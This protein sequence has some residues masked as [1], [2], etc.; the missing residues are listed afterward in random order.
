MQF[1][2][3]LAYA[4]SLDAQDELA[5]F[6]KEFHF[7]QIDGKNIVYLCGNSLGLQPKQTKIYLEK[8]LE[9]WANYAV[10]GHFKVAEPW[11][12]YHHLL[13]S[14]LANLLGAKP[15]EVTAMNNLTS[16]LHLMMVSFYRPSSKRYKILM[17]AGAFPSDMYAVESQVR[18][19]GLDPQKAIVEVKPREGEE[20]LRTV[21]I[22]SNIEKHADELALVLF[23][24]IQYYTGQ[25]FDISALA[26][27]TRDAGA[28]FGVDLAHAIGNVPLSLHEWEVDFAVWCTYKYLNSGPG[29]SAGLFVHEKHGRNFDL[30]RMA[31]WWGHDQGERFLMQKGFK[32]MP[33]AD[34]WQQANSNILPLAAQRASLDLFMK[35][36]KDQL[37]AKSLLLTAYLEYILKEIDGGKDIIHIITPQN[38]EERGAQLSIS[39]SRGGRPVFDKLVAAGVIGDWREPNVI[40]M[41]PAPLYNSFEDV[42][43]FG[44]V[45]RQAMA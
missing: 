35:A 21:D 33:G 37:R 42:Y 32:P 13:K 1:E 6:R 27:A 34:G 4:Q 28:Y 12:T 29:S 40:R 11:F 2:F 9:K 3:N 45:F 5:S 41:A 19:H 18:M 39:I 16:N 17:E 8:E 31:G 24:G 7:P 43:K 20:L 25:F 44:E 26:A 30:P 23:P 10:E 36:G 14:P 22:I 15:E 38:P